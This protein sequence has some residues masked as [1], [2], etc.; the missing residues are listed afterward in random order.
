MYALILPLGIINILLVMM[1][2]L[3]GL[4]IIRI[5]FKAHKY[6]GI[7]LGISATLHGVIA[8]FFT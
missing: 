1:Q 3:S 5:S 4:R 8:I 7:A 2:L 6:F